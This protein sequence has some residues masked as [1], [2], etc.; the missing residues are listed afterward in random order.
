MIAYY[1]TSDTNKRKLRLIA[2]VN[3]EIF[4]FKNRSVGNFVKYIYVNLL[5]EPYVLSRYT[6]FQITTINLL[7]ESYCCQVMSS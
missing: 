2:V 5:Q 1:I 7:N 3:A 6:Y 4:K